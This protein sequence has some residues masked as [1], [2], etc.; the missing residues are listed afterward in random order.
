MCPAPCIQPYISGCNHDSHRPPSTHYRRTPTH[1]LYTS[2]S[3]Q[4][5]PTHTHTHLCAQHNNAPTL[6]V[7]GTDKF[8]D[9]IQCSTRGSHTLISLFQSTAFSPPT[10]QSLRLC[11]S[12]AVVSSARTRFQGSFKSSLCPLHLH[13]LQRGH[14][15]LFTAST[16]AAQPS[17]TLRE[18]CGLPTLA[19][20]LVEGLSDLPTTGSGPSSTLESL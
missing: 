17:P 18:M 6:R 7:P 13:Q 19:L 15:F 3:A 8:M 1:T 20:L 5:H 9:M 4:H 14:R 11:S 10:T 2:R 16:A 12:Q